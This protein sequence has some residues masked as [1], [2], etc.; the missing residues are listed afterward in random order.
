[1]GTIKERRY[2]NMA[3]RLTKGKVYDFIIFIKDGKLVALKDEHT[4]SGFVGRL[5]KNYEVKGF[6]CA[7][8]AISAIDYMVEILE[9]Q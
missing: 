5:S 3:A 1:V 8:D 6:I 9:D 4:E 2:S 7:V